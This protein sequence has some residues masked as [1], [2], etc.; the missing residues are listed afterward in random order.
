MEGLLMWLVKA[1]IVCVI[2]AVVLAVLQVFTAAKHIRRA[3]EVRHKLFMTQ[4]RSRLQSN[5]D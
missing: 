5:C 1:G 3:Q 4:V 2:V